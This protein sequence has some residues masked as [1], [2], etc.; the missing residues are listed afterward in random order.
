MSKTPII[1]QYI[2]L[3][4]DL[5]WGLG[6]LAAQVAHASVAAIHAFR[7]HPDVRIYL[8]D[9]PNMRKVVL[10]ADEQQII[11]LRDDLCAA[12]IDHF[13]WIEQPENLLSA[14]GLRPCPKE[15][16]RPYL[17]HL[18]LLKELPRSK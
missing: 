9:I 1:T 3:R 18:S 2:V 7:E 5:P 8:S 16:V 13:A 10:S 15:L 4:N 11:Q 12:K 6:A 14:I 17:K